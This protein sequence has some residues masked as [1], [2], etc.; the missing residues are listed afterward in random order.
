M[1][2]YSENKIKLSV[3]GH[4]MLRRAARL[5]PIYGA[6]LVFRF[7]YTFWRYGHF[8][9]PRAWIAAPLA[10]PA[11]DI[12]ANLLLMQAW[13][14]CAGSIGPA[15]SISTEWGAYF[16]FPALAML[17]LWRGR[18][19]ALLIAA[20]VVA[21]LVGTALLDMRTPDHAGALDA[22]D[23]TTAGPIMRCLGGFALGVLTCRA[24]RHEA[25]AK[26]AGAGVACAGALAWIVGGIAAGAP[27]G[28][29]YPA[30]PLLVLSLACGGNP[31]SGLFAAG[32]VVW[33]GEIS[34]SL[35]LLHIFMLHPL[36]VTRAVTRMALPLDVAD[37]VTSTMMFAVLLLA[38]ALAYRFIERPGRTII[39][40]GADALGK[41]RRSA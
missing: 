19:T 35:Y 23:G 40:R 37:A 22:W 38:S 21:L 15:W 18:G 1:A 4:F 29:I 3:F 33:L 28:V 31:I 20:S 8:D 27:D 2:N 24:V 26:W 7:C 12:P 9:V 17:G 41:V 6:I 25:V 32:A 11:T 16:A 5:Y 39:L 30:F 10:H 13:G 36:D 34:Y 14:I